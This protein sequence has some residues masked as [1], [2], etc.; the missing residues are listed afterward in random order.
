MKKLAL[1]LIFAL[2]NIGL[3]TAVFFS[4]AGVQLESWFSDLWFSIRGVRAPHPG[5]VVVAMDEESYRTLD[6][7]MDRP[8]PRS[9]H[10]QLVRRLAE[11]GARRIVF[12]VLFY[13]PGSDPVATAELAEALRTVPVFL[14]A[15]ASTRVVHGQA[16]TDFLEPFDLLKQSAAGVALALMP[17]D[18]G[19]V[20]RFLVAKP[21]PVSDVPSLAEAGALAFGPLQDRPLKHD[22]LKYYGP[23]G[24]IPKYS[25]QAVLEREV[26]LPGIEE[27]F[28]DKIV[29]VGLMLRTD[30][31][32]AQKDSYLTAYRGRTF[33]VEIHATAAANMLEASWL[34]RLDPVTEAW[35]LAAVI[36]LLTGAILSV[37]PRE[38]ALCCLVFGAGWVAI[39]YTGLLNDVFVPGAV[40]SAIVLPINLLVSSLYYYFVTRRSQLRIQR[41]FEFY[42]SP[43]MAAEMAHNP[44][45]LRLGGSKT[46]ATALFTDIAGF[47]DISEAMSAEEVAHMLNCY[48]TEVMDVIFERGG[49]LIKFIGDAVFVLFGSPI[50]IDDHAAKACETALE[51]QKEVERFNA[52]KR[53]PELHTRIGIHT[54]PMVVGNLGSERRFDFTA[55]GD[56]VN[57]ASR[58]EGINKYLGT[59]AMIT[60]ATRDQAK[61]VPCL[62]MGRIRVVGKK[63]AIDLYALL[64]PP[65]TAEIEKDWLRAFELF[66]A[67]QWDDA[68]EAY[69]SVI[70]REPR[71]KKAAALY[72]SSIQA[73]QKKPPLED[74]TGEISFTSK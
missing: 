19:Y 61:D 49:T 58:V 11:L 63:Q 59:S 73:Y 36:V 68:A 13:G 48:F 72:I 66:K 65:V 29:F 4:P 1:I 40:L 27:I 3:H 56:S 14:G 43:E 21:G 69:A 20:R 51:I 31:G 39:A 6:V 45:A 62:H 26:P 28:R 5:V 52:S 55:I 17:E 74:W 54:G 12:D 33:G 70:R 42:L 57:L 25:I 8:W 47:T 53:F 67:R 35:I 64:D 50:K 34:R 2:V 46:E 16:V 71:L 9:L 10:A 41:A 44:A 60:Q 24:T 30:T 15:E 37:Q 22:M 7:P 38:G 18:Q 23:A 32:P